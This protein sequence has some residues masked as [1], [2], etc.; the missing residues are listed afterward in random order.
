MAKRPPADANPR[1]A[2]T[3]AAAA[4]SAPRRGSELLLP[5]LIAAE[6]RRDRV[7]ERAR[8][9]AP[10]S[11]PVEVELVQDHRI[12]GDQLFALQAVDGEDRGV[13]PVEAAKLRRD[14]IQA[15]HR[16]AI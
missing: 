2:T 13:G 16:A 14:G 5:A 1:A 6:I 12:G 10:G 4:A 9:L 15:L 3:P 8:G 7:G 11:E